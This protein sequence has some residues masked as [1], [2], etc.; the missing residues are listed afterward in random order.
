MH[1]KP[2]IV[3]FAVAL[4][5]TGMAWSQSPSTLRD[6]VERA[7]LKNP[8]VLVK[9]QNFLALTSE[10]DASKGGWRPRVDLNLT[11]AR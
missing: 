1:F 5:T 10:E 8:E 2:S 3:A 11:A 6:A 7:V 9:N 4:F